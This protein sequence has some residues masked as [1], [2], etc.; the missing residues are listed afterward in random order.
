MLLFF[1]SVSLRPI[2]ANSGSVNRQEGHL[3]SGGH[4]I[5]ARQI[6]AHDAKIIEGD[7]REVRAA[8]AIA[9]GPHIRR[10]G[11]EPLVHFDVTAIS[12]FDAGE[13]QADAVGVG[14][15]PAGD[16]IGVSLQE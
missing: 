5:A 8:R 2:R 1:A 12:E 4:A 7:V 15:A 9:H 13:F 10:G 16:Q 6:V 11:F 14:R 3:P